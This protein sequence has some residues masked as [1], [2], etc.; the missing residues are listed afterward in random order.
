MIEPPINGP[1]VGPRTTT[2]PYR[3][4]ASPRCSGG[5]VSPRIACSVGPKTPAPSPCST[6]AAMRKGREGARPASIDAE[7]KMS[8]QAW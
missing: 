3:P 7:M 5:K 6:R 2:S 4:V 8:R 1:I